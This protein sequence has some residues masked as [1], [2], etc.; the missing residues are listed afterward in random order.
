MGSSMRRTF[1]ILSTFSL[2]GLI[3]FLSYSGD[4]IISDSSKPVQIKWLV[5]DHGFVLNTPGCQI[6]DWDP[7]DPSVQSLIT[8]VNSPYKCPGRPQFL[9]SRPNG[10]VALDKHLLNFYYGIHEQNLTCTYRPIIRDPG[11]EKERTDNKFYFGKPKQLIFEKP[12]KDDFLMV[13]C[14]MFEYPNL[15]QFIPL[16]PLKPDIEKEKSSLHQNY[17][18]EDHLNII[19][20]GIDSVSKLNFLRHFQ[21]TH[22]FIKENLAYIELK[23][24]TKVADNTFPNLVP[25]L[26]GQFI[27]H[28]WNETVRDMFFDDVDFI[29]KN[30][31]SR[32]YRTL[33]AEDAPHIA[34]FNYLKKGF[35]DPPADYY[36]RPFALAVEKSLVRRESRTNCLQSRF[37][38]NILYSY[39]KDFVKTMKN[40]PYFSFTF[41]ARLTHDSLN[42]AGYADEPTFHLLRDLHD[43][44]ALNKSL[45]ILF[46]DH[47]IRF[48]PIRQT[49]IGKFEERMPFIYLFFPQWFLSKYP[50]R[51]KNLR[52]NQD[53]LTTPFDVHATL[54]HLL[55]ITH[56]STAE[57][58]ETL[59][60]KSSNGLSLMNPIPKERTCE[61]ANILPHWCPCQIHKPIPIT[62][63]VVTNC[64]LA[65]MDTINELLKPFSNSCVPLKMDKILD[66]RFGQ[67]NDMVLRFVKHQND[68]INRHVVLGQK[69]NAPGDYLIVISAKPSGGIFEGTVRYDVEDGTYRVL[70]DISRLNVYGNQ[71]ICISNARMRKFCFCKSK[72]TIFKNFLKP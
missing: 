62:E 34:T 66:A 20:V 60:I 56:Y 55:N 32:G 72:T 14:T 31:S 39:L 67:A 15:T 13:K 10:M 30:Y 38:M 8:K 5:D 37:E 27:E 69:I 24:Y 50:D 51:A 42:N 4:E 52:E 48:G 17:A 58:N 68:V 26:T 41:V 65:L 54:V 43:I 16:V 25:F 70:D 21:K 11:N 2:L 35:R 1:V 45:L 57:L 53:R 7:F 49:Y 9:S 12:L 3:I 18:E 44:G 22:R 47:G 36:F 33:F 63:P 40:R 61:Q 23:G 29:W 28:Y 6:P 64:A 19:I 59:S 46:S 71:S